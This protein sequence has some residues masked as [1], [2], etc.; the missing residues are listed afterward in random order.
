MYTMDDE[1]WSK[2]YAYMEVALIWR[3]IS[4]HLVL[5]FNVIR[6][7]DGFL[8]QFGI[9]AQM[10]TLQMPSRGVQLISKRFNDGKIRFAAVNNNQ[11]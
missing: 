6:W 5:R 10:L 3:S 4:T 7:E 11:M 1:F 8:F 9:G 2:T